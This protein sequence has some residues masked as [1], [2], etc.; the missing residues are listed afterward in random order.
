MGQAKQRK[1]LLGDQYGKMS[2]AGYV[3]ATTTRKTNSD[4]VLVG[5]GRLAKRLQGRIRGF[6]GKIKVSR[7]NFQLL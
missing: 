7:R 2:S 3:P 6:N 1:L 5:G 4:N